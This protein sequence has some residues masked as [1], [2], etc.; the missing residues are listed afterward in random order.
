MK[1]LRPGQIPFSLKDVPKIVSYSDGEGD[2]AGVGIAVWFPCG[3]C[4][5]GYLQL[6]PEVRRVWSRSST[7]G[8]NYDIFEI[9]A[10]GLA[11]ILWNWLST[12]PLNCLCIHFIDNESAL[13]SLVKGSS[14]VLSGECITA[15]THSRIAAAGLWTW[16]DRIASKDNPVDKLSRGELKGEWDLLEIVFPP[17]LL[18]SLRRYLHL[19]KS[20]SLY[21]YLY[22]YSYYQV[23]A[24]VF[25]DLIVQVLRLLLR[26]SGHSSLFVQLSLFLNNHI[27]RYFLV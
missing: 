17:P 26:S 12:C 19:Y 7:I 20:G 10:V 8:R 1:Y 5:G 11:L 23:I 14:A 9:E 22:L 16:F 18:A 6:P 25:W 13:A 2:K 21:F 4:I 15:F 27:A 24:V 3:R